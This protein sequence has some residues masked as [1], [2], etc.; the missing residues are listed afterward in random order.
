MEA[1]TSK[2]PSTHVPVLNNKSSKLDNKDKFDTRMRLNNRDTKKYKDEDMDVDIINCTNDDEDVDIDIVNCT[3]DDEAAGID[4]VNSNNEDV[5]V[6]IIN[7]TDDDDCDLVQPHYDDDATASSSSFDDTHP[8]AGNCESEVMSEFRA[9]VAQM[10]GFSGSE[11]EFPLRKRRVT[12]HWRKFVE[13]IMW[14]CKWVELQLMKFQSLANAYDKELENYKHTKHLQYGNFELDGQCAKT[15]PFVLDSQRE[16]PMK[17]KIRRIHEETDKEFF[18]SQHNLF[19]YFATGRSPP[20]HGLTMDDDQR[21]LAPCLSAEKN[22][23]NDFKVP[24]DILSL[25]YGDDHSL[26]QLLWK[27]EVSQSRVFEMKNRLDS[28]MTDNEGR[29]SSAEDVVLEESRNALTCSVRE[30]DFPTNMDG[31]SVVADFASQL[32]ND[33]VK[34]DDGLVK[35]ENEDSGHGDGSHHDDVSEPTEQPQVA[36]RKRNTEGILI[37]NRRTKK[38]QTDAGVVKIHPIENLQV[39]KEEKSNSPA[40]VSVSENSSQSEE[41]A[42]KIRS[43]SKLTAPKNKKKRAARTRRKSASSLWSRKTLG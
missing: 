28:V 17:R 19:S 38:T 20:P 9:D 8:D 22:V 16:K 42:P 31:P 13:P 11:N 5:E 26:E 23:G 39:P 6:D 29:I 41:P 36:S 37:Y 32:I 1:S 4:I 30:S 33:L 25:D 2:H 14:R 18:M 35:R 34:S 40:H 27:I 21:N 15:V 10:S 24:D 7:C 12:S 43:V 3:N